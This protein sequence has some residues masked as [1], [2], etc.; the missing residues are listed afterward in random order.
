MFRQCYPPSDLS[1]SRRVPLWLT[2]IAFGFAVIAL[3]ATVNPGNS[4]RIR[5]ETFTH[6][7]EQTNQQQSDALPELK[8]L[9]P[10]TRPPVKTLGLGETHSYRLKLEANQY[11]R[12][13]GY[14]YGVDSAMA[15]YSPSGEKLEEVLL[16]T[17]TD[18]QKPLMWT[19]KV[20]GVYRFEVRGLAAA[21]LSGKYQLAAH[22][23]DASRENEDL[24]AADRAHFEGVR[25]SDIGTEKALRAALERFRAAIPH[26][27]ARPDLD[28]RYMEYQAL[29]YLGDTYFKLSEYQE[30][31]RPYE[32]ALVIREVPGW[33]W[34]EIWASINIA[35][36][37]EML[38]ETDQALKYFQM[39]V[40]DAEKSDDNGRELANACT[41][42]AR[43]Y[44]SQGEKQKA[45]EYLYRAKPNWIS[46]NLSAGVPDV[47]G[48]GRVRLLSGQLDAS[49]GE[50]DEAIKEIQQAAE[51]WR[52]TSDSV[53][54]VHALNSL[55][56]TQFDLH[57]LPSALASFNE[58]FQLSRQSG[59]RENEGYA[60]ANLGQVK[61]SLGALGQAQ[62]FLQQALALMETIG[63]RSGQAYVLAKLGLLTRGR[64]DP[65]EAMEY[66]SRALELREAVHDREGTAEVL[67]QLAVIQK[68][69]GDLETSRLHIERAL[70]LI[71]FVRA[72]FSGPEMRSAYSSNA[73]NYYE[74]HIDLLMRLHERNPSA[75]YDRTAFEASEQARARNLVET[76]FT[77]GV[78]IRQGVPGELLQRE[79]SIEQRLKAKSEYQTRL[80]SGAHAPEQG[81]QAANDVDALTNEYREIEAQIRVAS[82]RYAA[83]TQPQPLTLKE[84]QSQTLDSGTVLLEYELG[85]ERS[86]LWV[87]TPDSI[88]AFQLPKRAE[89]ESLARRFYLNTSSPT[90]DRSES[91]DSAAALSQLLFGPVAD[92]LEHK[93]LLIVA[94][95]AL[96]YVPFAA[97][98]VPKA[99]GT[100][101]LNDGQFLAAQHE[102]VSLPSA[103]SLVFLRRELGS[104]PSAPKTIAMLADPVFA[105]DDPR[106]RHPQGA[107]LSFR[108]RVNDEGAR[109][110]A[111]INFDLSLRDAAAGNGTIRRLPSTRREA[112][113]IAGLVPKAERKLALDFDASLATALS[114]TMSQYRILHFATHGLLD[115][116]RPELSGL[117]LSLVDRDGR[118]QDGFLQVHEIYNLKLPADVVVLSACRTALGRDVK[119]EGLLGITRG[120]MYAGAARVVASLWE[121]DSRATAELMTRFYREML[122][123]KRSPAAALRAAQTSM[124]HDAH[125]HSPYYWAGFVIQ[126]EYR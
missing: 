50:T 22:L 33:R 19:S 43:F 124:A 70:G 53:R 35:R 44:L 115:S 93:R 48:G 105:P 108:Q 49:L 67:Y 60:L 65:R 72:S 121:V 47:D 103:S 100:R 83:L 76:L 109:T 95:G 119:G 54:L 113:A 73:R 89:V 34:H 125:W 18:G 94:E 59:N 120:F 10:D 38:G 77:S 13:Q 27:Q 39:S 69:L 5:A 37:Y 46:N 86:F 114:G 26:W 63:N 2:R 82:P 20:A 80:L 14:F 24:V 71:E 31:L 1:P 57:D 58:A 15:L 91:D 45:L 30:S 61:M 66:F 36:S 97:L 12:V 106:V 123:N 92:R 51:A 42:L 56:Q 85:E 126:G 116:Q 88:S 3:V 112:V 25:F 4:G 28:S 75:G 81:A 101:T 17:T 78:D 102:I 98:P 110:L 23:F 122:T 11:V 87:V 29:M 117:V 32:Q 90:A 41:E 6:Q 64:G 62:E 52:D 118:P 16:P 40:R 74:F 21:H 9:P 7:I 68:E 107:K 84:I 111:A 55:G 96:Q 79:R 8:P 99:V 104:R